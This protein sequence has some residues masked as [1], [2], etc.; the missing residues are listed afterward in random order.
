[1]ASLNERKCQARKTQVWNLSHGNDNER[2]R[3]SGCLGF[4]HRPKCAD[5]IPRVCADQP[6]TCRDVSELVMDQIDLYRDTRDSI[7]QGAD[8]DAWNNMSDAARDRA[9]LAELRAE[10]NLHPALYPPEDQHVVLGHYKVC[11]CSRSYITCPFI[12]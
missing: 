5:R 10:S 6:P 8:A 12:P 4:V 1:M 7:V 3:D 11:P 2:Q 9:L